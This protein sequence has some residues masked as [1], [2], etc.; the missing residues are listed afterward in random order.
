M[1]NPVPGYSVSTAFKK[2]GSHWASC[3]WHT[4]QDY[5]APE[6]QTIVA[7]RGGVCFHVNYGSSFGNHQFV[8]EPGD[9]TEDFY[10]HCRT[11]PPIGATF[12]IGEAIAEVGQEGNATGPHLHF[13][14]H[15]TMGQWNCG[16]MADPMQ[17][18]NAAG[19]TAPPTTG[20]P[21][22]GGDVWQDKLKYGQMDS[23]SVRR[24]QYQLNGVSL[25]G[26]Q[27][28]PITGNY[29]DQTD[30][31]VRLWQEQICGDTPDPAGASFLGPNQ[32]ARMFPTPPYVIK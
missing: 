26:G 19:G 3:G 12:G 21:Y 2:T 27:E 7:A 9:G 15:P 5:A 14:R 1:V 31:E 4:G 24:L 10:A 6:G 16:N 18:H 11:R 23:D 13:E 28:L 8:I 29:L 25:T 22:A 20:S 17:S 30:H 32:T